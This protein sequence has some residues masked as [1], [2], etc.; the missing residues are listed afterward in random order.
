VR[1]SD[2]ITFLR[3]SGVGPAYANDLQFIQGIL[4]RLSSSAW[5]HQHSA[6]FYQIDPELVTTVTATG[7]AGDLELSLSA[8]PNTFFDR[9][10]DAE[11]ENGDA[12]I[13]IYGIEDRGG[14]WYFHLNRPLEAD[15]TAS[16]LTLRRRR[17]APKTRTGRPLG[18]VRSNPTHTKAS[19]DTIARGPRRLH[20]SAGSRFSGAGIESSDTFSYITCPYIPAPAIE[21]TLTK[22]G[23]AG[24]NPATIG[25]YRAYTANRIGPFIS[26]LS[27]ASAILNYPGIVAGDKGRITVGVN[28][29]TDTVFIIE[30]PIEAIDGVHGTHSKT[31]LRVVAGRNAWSDY[32]SKDF[33]LDQAAILRLPKFESTTGTVGLSYAGSPTERKNVAVTGWPGVKQVHSYYDE[34]D[35]DGRFYEVMRSLAKHGET[36]DGKHLIAARSAVAALNRRVS[37][38]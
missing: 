19:L 38:R 25:N 37:R 2:I 14:S 34:V 35:F 7:V 31:G 8:A 10:L 17:Y 23:A 27:P 6:F 32:L 22:V 36:G 18:K 26:E 5:T 20:P 24:G 16:V 29:F 28:E 1:V 21:P 4:E 9:Y 11:F 12:T 15:I 13:A 30:G 3:N 33:E